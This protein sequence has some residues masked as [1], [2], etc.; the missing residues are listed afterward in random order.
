MTLEECGIQAES[1]MALQLRQ[2]GIKSLQV[3]KYRRRDLNP[4]DLAVTGF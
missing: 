1:D 3:K 4:H 2:R